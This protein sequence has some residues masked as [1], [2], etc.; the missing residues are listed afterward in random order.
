MHLDT[1]SK[2]PPQAK[3]LC[4]YSS[5]RNSG[6]IRGINVQ[7]CLISVQ[8]H[9]GTLHM[10]FSSQNVNLEFT[11]RRLT[12]AGAAAPQQLCLS[13]KTPGIPHAGTKYPVQ[14]IPRFDEQPWP[15]K[16][17]EVLP[18]CLCFLHV[19]RFSQTLIQN[20]CYICKLNQD[21]SGMV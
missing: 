20:V 19:G 12:V 17:I 14:G 18:F 9:R 7:R 6:Q 16:G 4:P 1:F 15:P 8:I 10:Q 2:M 3:Q 13:G 21:D 5:Y 11:T